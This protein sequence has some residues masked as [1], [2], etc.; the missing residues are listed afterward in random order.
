MGRS[1]F[2][3]IGRPGAVPGNS[4]KTIGGVIRLSK[5][6]RQSGALEL[7]VNDYTVPGNITN[8][9]WTN[10]NWN[11]EGAQLSFSVIA[12]LTKINQ[13]GVTVGVD[14]GAVFRAN[15]NSDNY[16]SNSSSTSN[17]GTTITASLININPV[18]RPLSQNWP[19][20]VSDFVDHFKVSARP[21]FNPG[22][23]ADLTVET[24]IRYIP[25]RF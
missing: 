25:D 11:S 10:N 5:S 2:Q 17:V 14:A 16:F 9:P 12:S 18:R 4:P 22:E 21:L 13:D 20:W 7:S 15:G 1:S 3:K 6:A 23:I 24:T 19:N 8:I